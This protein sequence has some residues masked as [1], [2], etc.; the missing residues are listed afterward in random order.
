MGSI[1]SG[2]AIRDAVQSGDI[3]IEP[4]DPGQINPVSY[5]VTLGEKVAVYR[6]WVETYRNEPQPNPQDGSRFR[7]LDRWLDIREEPEVES[8]DIDPERGW[9]LLPGIGYLM[10]TRERICT[11]RY[12]PILDGK[13]S[14]GR[15][16][17]MIH[18]T[19]GFGDPG[20]DGQYT[21]EVQ[22]THPVRVFP[23][24]RVGQMRFQTVEG[25]T[26]ESYQR[27]GNYTGRLASGPVPSQ[28]WKMFQKKNDFEPIPDGTR[29][30]NGGVQ[31][32]MLVGPCA[33]GAWH[34]KGE[35]RQEAR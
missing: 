13:S 19:A 2:A 10:H 35:Q 26:A 15:L 20:F 6:G 21:L 25:G 11:E 16:F 1:L 34:K 24:M 3:R 32:D 30:Y 17:M 28:A 33:C 12:V 23:G 5:D 31:C 8:F 22:V 7:P 29:Y 14:I 9:A 4:Y 18:V 27:R